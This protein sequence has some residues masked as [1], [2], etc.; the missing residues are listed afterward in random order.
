MKI[1][2]VLPE[3]PQY[4]ETFFNSKIKGL[5][6]SGF[7]VTVLSNAKADKNKNFKVVSAYKIHSDKK[8]RQ[9]FLTVLIN[10]V[11]YFRNPRSYRKFSGLEKKD[12]KSLQERMKSIYINAHILPL[13][14]DWLHFG[15]ATTALKKENTA[16]A[17]GAKMGVSFR[18]FDMNVYPLKNPGCYE[19]L[20]RNVDKIHSISDYLHKKAVA[21]G[22]DEKKPFQKITPA[23]DI[24]FFEMKT[25]AGKLS[26]PVKILTVGRLNWVKDHETAISAMKILKDKGISFKYE[27]VGDG[28][29]LER[30]RYAVHQAG[31]EDVVTFAGK[32]SH[33]EIKNIMQKSDIYL[34]T[35]LQE[36]FC[37]SVIE[38]QASGLLCIVSDA[39]GLKENVVDGK[40]GWVVK[41]RDHHAFAGKIIDVIRTAEPERKKITTAARE[42]IERDFRIEDQQ[43]KFKKFYTE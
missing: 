27:I 15:F 25:D 6:N 24:S 34:Q 21:L 23:I 42:R 14:L 9:A 40:T 2:L 1:G 36:G 38:A 41:R 30:L 12:G 33:H 8:L 31:V 13:R 5:Q 18:G 4:S 3:A 22:L 11:T 20:W 39:D 28:K 35:S 16:K 10:I 19:K 32:K 17:I 43:I 37:V 26:T 29:E 7:E